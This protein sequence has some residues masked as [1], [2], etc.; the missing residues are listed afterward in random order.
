MSVISFL[1]P[2]PSFLLNI[3]LRRLRRFIPLTEINK[4]PDEQEMFGRRCNRPGSKTPVGAGRRRKLVAVHLIGSQN[5]GGR[6]VQDGEM[7]T[8]IGQVTGVHTQVVVNGRATG[9]ERAGVG[10]VERPARLKSIRSAEGRVN[11]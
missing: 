3:H 6:N 5:I 9:I 2:H 4:Q 11:A 1:N 10:V 7:P 8:Q